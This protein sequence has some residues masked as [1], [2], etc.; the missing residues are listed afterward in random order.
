MLA[1]VTAAYLLL[2][3][4]LLLLLFYF[5]LFF[6]AFKIIFALHQFYKRLL[7]H[8]KGFQSKEILKKQQ[9]SR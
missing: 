5:F 1:F 6:L 4:L 7:Q 8:I 2:L 9:K 3:L